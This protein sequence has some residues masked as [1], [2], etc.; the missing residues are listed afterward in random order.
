MRR[1]LL[2]LVLSGLC[3]SCIYDTRSAARALNS[4]S[5]VGGHGGEGGTAGSGGA[6][7]AG[8]AAGVGGA[9]GSGGTGGTIEPGS[10]LTCESCT[11]DIDCV[12]AEHRCVE[13]TFM[14]NR[15]PDDKTGFCLRIANPLPEEAGYDCASPYVTV[16]YEGQSLSG[17]DPDTYCSIRSDLTNCNAVLAYQAHVDCRIF[18]DDACP[19]GGLCDF[20]RVGT[21]WQEACTYRCG[22]ASECEGPGRPA[23]SSQY[24]GW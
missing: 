21:E 3:G 17:G 9:A 13:M 20:I 18:G 6:A 14:N 8:G 15:F 1:A 2:I 24:C 16:M 7:G 10:R 4:D 12:D 23:C 5:G 11:A 19:E 22:D